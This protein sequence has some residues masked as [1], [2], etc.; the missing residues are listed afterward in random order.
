M[1]LFPTARSLIRYESPFVCSTT[2]EPSAEVIYNLT[3]A[4]SLARIFVKFTEVTALATSIL[5]S[6]V[7]VLNTG[8]ITTPV[9]VVN[10]IRSAS[11]DCLITYT[12]YT[13]T[14]LESTSLASLTATFTR[15]VFAGSVGLFIRTVIFVN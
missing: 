4:L 13:F 9:S 12:S 2:F 10:W 3:V 15:Y 11:F 5:Y 1:M 7:D 8:V 6:F 14:L